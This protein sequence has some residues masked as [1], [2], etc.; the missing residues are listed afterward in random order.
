M[1]ILVGK[2][3]GMSW[4]FRD[5]G[6][7]CPVTLIIAK[8][9]E[10]AEIIESEKSGY[11]A[12]K[13]K[14]TDRKKSKL[15]EFRSAKKIEGIKPGDKISVGQFQ[16]SDKINV[17]GI[18]RGKGFAGAI[19]RHG[20]SRGPETHGSGHHRRVGSIGSMFPQHVL[21]GQKMPG[22][23]GGQRTT[24]KNLEIVDVDPRKNLLLVSGAIPGSKGSEIRLVGE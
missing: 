22:R 12:I 9:A 3:F 7:V 1:K 23:M 4:V 20:F 8:P 13:I 19:K 6:R 11:D 16:V 14:V 18:S 21:K 24:V 5:D 10:V 17:I 15:M 2:K